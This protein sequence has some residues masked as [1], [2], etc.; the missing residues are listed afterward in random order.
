MGTVRKVGMVIHP[1]ASLDESV[2]FYRDALGL[3]LRFRDGDRFCAF[4][5][6]GVTIA[7][8]SGAESPSDVPV[9]SYQVDDLEGAVAALQSAGGEVLRPVE[10]G[11]HERRALLRDP[12]GNAFVVYARKG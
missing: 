7:L 5:G 1:V 11:P 12:S 9:V 4:D 2:A 10:E 6:G 8:A 3:P